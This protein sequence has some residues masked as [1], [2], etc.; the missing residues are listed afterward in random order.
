MAGTVKDPVDEAAF[1]KLDTAGCADAHKGE[2]VAFRV[3]GAGQDVRYQDGLGMLVVGEVVAFD[4][5]D[6]HRRQS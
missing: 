2:Q 6:R 4:D 3:A 1:A 5:I